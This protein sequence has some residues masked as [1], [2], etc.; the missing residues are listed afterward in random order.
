ML[1]EYSINHTQHIHCYK[2]DNQH[3]TDELMFRD[4]LR[5]DK[6]AFQIYKNVKKEAAHK[7]RFSPHEYSD[8]K[9]EC[10]YE[11]MK[12]AKSFVQK[13]CTM[14]SLDMRMDLEIIEF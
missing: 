12:R 14:V 5:V 7:F 3:V 13:K 2:K 10:I 1:S 11:I 9:S 6:E 8:Y 4:F